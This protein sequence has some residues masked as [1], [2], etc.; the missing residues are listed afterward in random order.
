MNLDEEI[1]QEAFGKLVGVSQSRI[2]VLLNRGVLPHDGTGGEWLLA[3]CENLREVAAGRES[4][5]G[6]LDLVQERAALARAQRKGIEIKNAI[7]LG[8]YAP[9]E[10]LEMV[11]SNASAAV[12]ERIEALPAQ[13][14]MKVPGLP[15]EA[16]DAIDAVIISARNEWARAAVSAA[17]TTESGMD[18][19]DEDESPS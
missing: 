1:T 17:L 7:A 16:L 15:Q 14:R 10:M 4:E 18:D 2:S 12:V 8:T 13:L 9:I 5:D 6:G 11:L 3:Y 19:T